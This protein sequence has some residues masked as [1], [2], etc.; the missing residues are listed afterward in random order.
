MPLSS[1]GE[2]DA[3]GTP[4]GKRGNL[5]FTSA[6]EGGNIGK[7]VVKKAKH[8]Y[9]IFV[10]PDT[11]NERYRLWFHF[12]VIS[13]ASNSHIS[14]SWKVEQRATPLARPLGLVPMRCAN[15]SISA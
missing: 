6:F 5:Q 4:S 12:K 3:G 10:R 14:H 8:D 1:A 11:E 15:E 2:L 7:V 13:W 9:S